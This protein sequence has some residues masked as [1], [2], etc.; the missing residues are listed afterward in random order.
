MIAL[1]RAV[2]I[3]LFFFQYRGSYLFGSKSLYE[4]LFLHGPFLRGKV[5]KTEYKARVDG[6][7]GMCGL[8]TRIT[9]VSRDVIE[10]YARLS[11]FPRL[12]WHDPQKKYCNINEAN[13]IAARDAQ[14][15]AAR[16]FSKK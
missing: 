14:Y 1:Q 8:I 6:L 9:D 11:G 12:V 13:F 4:P 15:D 2:F 7:D 10:S 16:T 5:T 3:N